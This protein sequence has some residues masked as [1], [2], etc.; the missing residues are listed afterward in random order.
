VITAS[1]VAAM[2]ALLDTTIP[3]LDVEK[4]RM[5]FGVGRQNDSTVLDIFVYLTGDEDELFARRAAAE[6][7]T[8]LP[9]LHARVADLPDD[10]EFSDEHTLSHVNVDHGEIDVCYVGSV[11]ATWHNPFRRDETGRWS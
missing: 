11:N 7:I 9:D 5:Y 10:P 1:D 8:A 4:G 3:Y 2:L 6:A